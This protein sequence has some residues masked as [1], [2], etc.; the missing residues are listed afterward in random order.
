MTG[1]EWTVT[2]VLALLNV[3]TFVLLAGAWLRL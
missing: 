3:G 2:V 1:I